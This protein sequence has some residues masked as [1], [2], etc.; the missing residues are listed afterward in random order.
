M[1]RD[2]SGQLGFANKRAESY[3]RLRELLDP[4]YGATLALPPDP[5]VLADLT[6]P[7]WKLTLQGILLES[8]DDIRGRLG[9]S[10]DLGDAIVMACNLGSSYSSV[11]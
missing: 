10:P 4:A 11:F 9:R 3:W 2:R 8:K 6:A 7:R 1:Y 5:K